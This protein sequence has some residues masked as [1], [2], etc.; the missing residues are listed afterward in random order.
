MY[1]G[2][3][4]ARLYMCMSIRVCVCVYVCVCVC[5]CVY[6]CLCRFA[7]GGILH[8]AITRLGLKYSEGV[9][10]GSTARCIA[11]LQVRLSGPKAGQ[12][13]GSW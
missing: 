8:P 2:F 3:S 1:R 4:C 9:L 10:S 13:G 12:E 7:S 5:V 11:M 6:V